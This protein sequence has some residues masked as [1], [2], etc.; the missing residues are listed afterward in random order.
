VLDDY[1][2]LAEE[3]AI[4]GDVLV[5]L[6][7]DWRLHAVLV[8]SRIG[9]PELLAVCKHATSDEGERQPAPASLPATRSPAVGEPRADR[10]RYHHHLDAV[11]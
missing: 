6:R 7:I 2:Q 1:P 8:R 10:A 11:T 3:K 5:D 9:R 4:D